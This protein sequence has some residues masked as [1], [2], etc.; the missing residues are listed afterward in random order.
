RGSPG[1][2]TARASR[3]SRIARAAAA[4]G[5]ACA[6]LG[7]GRPP[8]DDAQKADVFVPAGP[9]DGASEAAL[10]PEAALPPGQVDRDGHPLVTVLLVPGAYRDAYN[11]HPSFEGGVDRTLQDALEARLVALYTLALGDGGPDPVDWDI[12]DGGTHPLLPMLLTDV[13]LVDTAR[14]C[15]ADGGFA[16]SYLDIERE[17]YLG[18]PAH[19]SC[20]GRTPD[21]DVVDETLTLL[22]TDDRSPVT[23]GVAGP[24]KPATA[25]FPYL[26]PP[27]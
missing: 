8:K 25:S 23:Q 13:L 19:T 11:E 24:T 16:P 12:P 10:L 1:V 14:P 9:P 7:C 3:S 6:L 2:R 18:G 21:D 22:V 17:I 27:N 4:A 15:T 26:A 20:G 5:C